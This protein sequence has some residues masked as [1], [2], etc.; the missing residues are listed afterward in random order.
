M[1]ERIKILRKFL[2]LTQ[3]KFADKLGLKRQTIAAY[4]IGTI[5]PSDST[6][7]LI[8]REFNVNEEWLRHGIGEMYAPVNPDD[9]YAA[10]VGKL[11]RTDNETIIRWVNAIS[12]TNPDVLKQIEEFMKKLL[13]LEIEKE[14]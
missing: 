6:L 1:K 3:Q 2:N 11:Q 8:C 7:L 4:E 9:R 13:D 14:V 5:E 12:E 10:N